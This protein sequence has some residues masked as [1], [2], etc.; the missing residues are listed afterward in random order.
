MDRKN[1]LRGR[2]VLRDDRTIVVHPASGHPGQVSR[3]SKGLCEAVD[4]LM[5]NP[6]RG[7]QVAVMPKAEVTLRLARK[8]APRY[9]AAGIEI[10]LVGP[11]GEVEDIK[12]T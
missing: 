4:L 9:A 10:A 11:R 5:A 8:L 12:P 3:L 1:L 6:S 7:R 2:Y